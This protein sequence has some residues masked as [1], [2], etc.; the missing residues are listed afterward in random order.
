MKSIQSIDP[1]HS[2]EEARHQF[3][4]WRAGRTRRSRTPEDL[5]HRAVSLLKHHRA[6]H[7]CLALGINAT[8]LKSW[9]DDENNSS[10]SSVKFTEMPSFVALDAAEPP[11]IPS[12]LDNASSLTSALMLELRGHIR[13]HFDSVQRTA[14]RLEALGFRSALAGAR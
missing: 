2:L 11:P 4:H 8:A 12:A 13:V 9:A 14:E 1:G 5:R 10:S 6:F 3:D 7:V